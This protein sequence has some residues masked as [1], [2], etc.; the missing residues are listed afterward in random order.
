MEP[1][2]LDFYWNI[3]QDTSATFAAI[4]GPFLLKLNKHVWYLDLSY[5]NR[6]KPV[7][8]SNIETMEEQ[9]KSCK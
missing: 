4:V 8:I 6:I 9:D 1:T 2:H 5:L 7:E 3:D